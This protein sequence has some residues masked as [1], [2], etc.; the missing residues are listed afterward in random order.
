M[1]EEVARRHCL[2]A[3]GRSASQPLPRECEGDVASITVHRNEFC[4]LAEKVRCNG[5]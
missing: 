2:A 4:I 1:A 5:K 3:I